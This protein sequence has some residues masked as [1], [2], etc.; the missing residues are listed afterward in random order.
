[1]DMGSHVAYLT[2]LFMESLAAKHPGKLS[3]IH[4]FPG[5]VVTESFQDEQLPKWFK[6]TWRFVL[7]P[8]SPLF[9]VPRAESGE[10]VLFL[11][12]SRFPP[13]STAE[14]LKSWGGGEIADGVFGGGD[15][16][17]NWDTEIIPMKKTY[18]KLRV[19]GMSERCWTHTMHAFEGI[20]AGKVF[21]G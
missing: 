11:A 8:F 16:R 4:Y 19:E 20:E 3:M 15:Y 17:S 6:Y 7:T 9:T 18:K 12:S 10:R 2:T 21:K 14:A 5:L 1:M 13:R